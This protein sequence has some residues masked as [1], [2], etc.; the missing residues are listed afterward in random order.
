MSWMTGLKRDR[1]VFVGWSGLLLFPT[2]YLAI[3]GHFTGTTFVTSWYTHGLASSY[4]EGANFLTRCGLC[5]RSADAMGHSL[6]LLWGPESQGRLHQ[7][8][9]TWRLLWSLC[10][11]PRCIC[12]DWFHASSVRTRTSYRNPSLQCDCFF[13]SYCRILSAVFLIYPLGQSS[14][15]LCTVVW[16]GCDIQIPTIPSGFP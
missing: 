9:P 12:S 2:A 3:G 13:R 7:V 1:F 5:Q 15:V 8:V 14:L 11:S 6:L 16:C 10:C 4:L